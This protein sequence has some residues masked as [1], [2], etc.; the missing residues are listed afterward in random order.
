MNKFAY[1]ILFSFVVFLL[2]GCSHDMDANRFDKD[3]TV[4]V[5]LN[6]NV[7]L[8]DVM[9]SG[10]TRA[11]SDGYENAADRNEL[12]HT[13]RIIVVR[14]DD[15]VEENRFIS[16]QNYL[17]YYGDER[18]KV[19]GN[20]TKRIYLFAN[21]ENSS[22]NIQ[23][24]DGQEI[25]LNDRL[26]QI[27]E[28]EKFP[29]DEFAG[30]TINLEKNKQI[31]TDLSPLPMNE[32]HII[33]VGATD[34]QEDL[35]IT[36]AAVK[37]SFYVTN[38]S[39]YK[40]NITGFA[41]HYMAQ[42]E[43]LLPRDAT[44]EDRTA[45]DGTIYKEITEYAV[46]ETEFYTYTYRPENYNKELSTQAREVPLLPLCYLLEG[47]HADS[48]GET[49]ENGNYAVSIWIDDAELRG[50]LP[51]LVQLPRNTH[52]KVYITI[53]DTQTDWTVDVRPYTEIILEPGF[54]L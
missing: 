6:I 18:F 44:Y 40:K 24:Q 34:Q 46:P 32:C 8:A 33:K 43:Y 10:T 5:N 38:E 11:E 16:F 21:E 13:L 22:I 52:V 3:D 47:K 15:T 12:M 23:K 29:I 17:Q 20:E 28:G 30:L 31:S 4:W 51:N 37:Y 26:N 39:S 7:S 25:K 41:I 53:R 27:K 14:P 48:E 19:H 50:T 42:K 54:G 36:R 49:K 35:F 45:S 2:S 9:Y 1:I